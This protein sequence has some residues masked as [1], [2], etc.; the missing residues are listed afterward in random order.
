M[1]RT[2][3]RTVGAGV[4]RAAGRGAPELTPAARCLIRDLQT[5]R[6]LLVREHDRIVAA[7]PPGCDPRPDRAHARGEREVARRWKE[8]AALG[9]TPQHVTHYINK[10]GIR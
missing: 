7:T 3:S 2:T 6:R 5:A 9:L 1:T 8:L 10:E 4:G